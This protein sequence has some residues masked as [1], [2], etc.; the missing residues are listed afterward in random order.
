[1]VQM[2][3]SSHAIICMQFVILKVFFLNEI[4]DTQMHYNY[5]VSRQDEIISQNTC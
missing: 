1:M 3:D 2:V 4:N 5:D